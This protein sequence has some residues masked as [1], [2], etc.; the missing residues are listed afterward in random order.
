[1]TKHMGFCLCEV[2]IGFIFLIMNDIF[3]LSFYLITNDFSILI[4]FLLFFWEI[5]GFVGFKVE[6]ILVGW[7]FVTIL[8]PLFAMSF[9]YWCVSGG[10]DWVRK[11]Q[12]Q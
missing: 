11:V 10:R 9:P 7:G 4:L 3:L 12:S 6:G 1:M 2:I 5:N 8:W